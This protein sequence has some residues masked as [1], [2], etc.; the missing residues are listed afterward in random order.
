MAELPDLLALARRVIGGGDVS[1]DEARALFE[2]DSRGEDV[3]DLFYAAY[4]VRRHFHGNR[5]TFCSGSVAVKTW[6]LSSY[7]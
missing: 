6:R 4:K 7:V 5:V 2:I 3:F 1:R